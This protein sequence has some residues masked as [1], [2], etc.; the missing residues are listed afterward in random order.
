MLDGKK[1]NKNLY[2]ITELRNISGKIAIAE[3]EKVIKTFF[4]EI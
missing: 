1:Y 3:K 2:V 4:N